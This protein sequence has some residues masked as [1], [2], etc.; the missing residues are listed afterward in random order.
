GKAE[1]AGE[2]TQ[3]DVFR[4]QSHAIKGVASNLGLM[5]A[6]NRA[7]ELMRAR[8]SKPVRPRSGMCSANNPTR[9][10]AWPA[11]SA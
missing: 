10:K 8:P 11:T 6:S 7:G 4:E 3:W 2:A 5:R 9:S 1:Q